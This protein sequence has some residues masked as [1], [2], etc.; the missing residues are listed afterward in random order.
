MK[1]IRRLVFVLS[2]WEAGFSLKSSHVG[3]VVDKVALGQFSSP[4]FGFPPSGS[5]HLCSILI[6]TPSTDAL[7]LYKLQ[8][9]SVSWSRRQMYF[10]WRSPSV[11]SGHPPAIS[12]FWLR[13][14]VIALLCNLRSVVCSTLRVAGD[15]CW[16]GGNGNWMCVLR[17]QNAGHAVVTARNNAYV[18]C[19][20][21]PDCAKNVGL[22]IGMTRGLVLN[23]MWRRA[24]WHICTPPL[25]LKVL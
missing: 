24:V 13:N 12:T 19:A 2:P 22:Q 4:Y 10:P 14:Q 8:R 21:F 16:W 6:Q 11:H 17:Q 7:W 15:M 3:F 9:Y 5:F 20:I 23:G 1:W 18:M 25:Q